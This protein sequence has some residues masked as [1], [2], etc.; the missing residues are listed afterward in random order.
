M[1]PRR[2]RAILLG[3]LAGVR[4][5]GV[6]HHFGVFGRVFSEVFFAAFAAEI[7]VGAFFGDLNG[8][9]VFTEF[10]VGNDT[11]LERITRG[12]VFRMDRGNGGE[13]RQC[14][15]AEDEFGDVHYYS[16]FTE[17]GFLWVK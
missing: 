12:R 8:C 9:A 3:G 1:E 6:L 13:E 17:F 5:G 2:R 4:S 7:D 11:R 16:D 15:S 10:F 14:R